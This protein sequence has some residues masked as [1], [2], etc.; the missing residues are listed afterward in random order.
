M[1]SVNH[2]TVAIIMRKINGYL[3]KK[4]PYEYVYEN[5][6]KFVWEKRIL[7][8]LFAWLHTNPFLGPPHLR[9]NENVHRK[10]VS[11]SKIVS[12]S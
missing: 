10:A 5:L 6:S 1:K 4:K 12:T 3:I 2:A 9:R 7:R 11:F 8:P